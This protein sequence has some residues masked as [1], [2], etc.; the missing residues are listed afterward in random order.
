MSLLS[1]RLVLYRSTNHNPYVQFRLPEFE[2]EES[3]PPSTDSR[4]PDEGGSMQKE[5]HRLYKSRSTSALRV[6]ATLRTDSSPLPQTYPPSTLTTEASCTITFPAP[7]P[8]SPEGQQSSAQYNVSARTRAISLQKV[9]CLAIDGLRS[10]V[11]K[12]RNSHPEN[13]WDES[14]HALQR[15]CGAADS[16][17]SV[18]GDNHTPISQQ[19]Q[20]RASIKPMA[21]HHEVTTNTPLQ[22]QPGTTSLDTAALEQQTSGS[23]WARYIPVDPANGL[24]VHRPQTAC[25]RR[26]PPVLGLSAIYINPPAPFCAPLAIAATTGI[27]VLPINYPNRPDKG[28]ELLLTSASAARA[29]IRPVGYTANLGASESEGHLRLETSIERPDFDSEA[30][31]HPA[32]MDVIQAAPLAPETP[33]GVEKPPFLWPPLVFDMSASGG[34][35]PFSE[36]AANDD[37]TQGHTAFDFDP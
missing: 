6:S 11:G 15:C 27:D 32:D 28:L 20:E 12:S 3:P 8:P 2:S 25:D 4:R 30:T 35:I 29:P 37:F 21:V 16:S 23:R 18:R 36:F 7:P 5:S 22:H 9:P 14:V 19:L 24:P 17:C 26:V 13:L 33:T 31:D 1:P 10:H 34:T